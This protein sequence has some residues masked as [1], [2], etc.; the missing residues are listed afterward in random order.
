VQN[1]DHFHLKKLHYIIEIYIR[2]LFSLYQNEN[3]TGQY[4]MFVTLMYHMVNDEIDSKISVRG[5]SFIE[6]LDYLKKEGFKFLSISDAI[7]V[8]SGKRKGDRRSVLI[9]FDDGYIDNV[10]VALPGLISRGIP[11]TLFVPS[12]F[13]G[14]SNRWNP[15]ANYDVRHLSWEQLREWVS[16]GC[17]VG[18]HTLDHLSMLRLNRKE[19]ET[20]VVKNKIILEKETQQQVRSFA[21]PYGAFSQEAK[22]IV[23]KYFDIAFSVEEGSLN[24]KYDRYCVKRIWVNPNWNIGQFGRSIESV[25][26]SLYPVD[27]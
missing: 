1:L 6:Q 10:E 19:I 7:D 4:S 12:D 23:G 11:A 14:K 22:E 16:A 21:Y 9:T 3:E 24:P 17:D 18:G 20:T 25:L 8:I 15:R 27:F 26:N 2:T 5:N 13:V